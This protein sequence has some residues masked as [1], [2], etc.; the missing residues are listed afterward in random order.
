[1]IQQALMPARI[2]QSW[3]EASLPLALTTPAVERCSSPSTP[4]PESRSFAWRASEDDAGQ[5]AAQLTHSLL[6]HSGHRQVSTDGSTTVRLQRHPERHR[7]LQTSVSVNSHLP[8]I[9]P[10]CPRSL[11]LVLIPRS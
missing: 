7:V 3:G 10:A 1:M 2:S 11:A 8:S 5:S 4:S 9:F 6:L